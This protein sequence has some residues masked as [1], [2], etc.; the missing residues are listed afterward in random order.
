MSVVLIVVLAL[1]L[2][3]ACRVV[4]C[5]L[6]EPH[7]VIGKPGSV[8]MNRWYVLPR[9]RWFNIYLHEILRSD[10]DRALHDHPWVNASIVLKGGYWEVMPEH[11]PS[12]S[13]PVPPTRDVWR[14]AGSVVLRRPTAA[15][16]LVM[17]SFEPCWSLFVTGPNVRDW[18]FWCPRG[19]TS[20]SDFLS[21]ANSGEI[22][23]GCGDA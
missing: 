11:A 13:W 16:R 19:W 5:L 17:G 18:G 3:L 6:R 15:H 23:R 12:V 14:G 9:N 1:L 21:P 8:Y 20:Q 7:F 4:A 2:A 22:G 10:D